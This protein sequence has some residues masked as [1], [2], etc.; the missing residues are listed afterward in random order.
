MLFWSRQSLACTDGSQ[1]PSQWLFHGQSQIKTQSCRCSPL[2]WAHWG[3]VASWEKNQRQLQ[4]SRWIPSSLSLFPVLTKKGFIWQRGKHGW[5]RKSSSFLISLSCVILEVSAW[6]SMESFPPLDWLQQ[7]HVL[8]L[9]GSFTSSCFLCTA[10]GPE[11]HLK[12]WFE[13]S[14]S[15]LEWNIV[16]NFC[17]PQTGQL[18][19]DQSTL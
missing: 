14:K 9:L 2:D 17:F 19:R 18:L 15:L 13:F 12:M 8:L 3:S 16:W 7:F 6:I 11:L 10:E 5:S 1:I 4:I